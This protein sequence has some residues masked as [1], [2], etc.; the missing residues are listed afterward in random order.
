MMHSAS[1]TPL[2]C[3]LRQ[4]SPSFSFISTLSLISQFLALSYFFLFL[5]LFLFPPPMPISIFVPIAPIST[6]LGLADYT[7][8][9]THDHHFPFP[10]LFSI[11]LYISLHLCL[12]PIFAYP[13]NIHQ[14]WP[15]LLSKS[16]N[17]R[18]S[19]TEH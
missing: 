3:P 17:S 1:G 15:C 12:F 5:T 13:T 7:R 18:P 14:P 9:S 19:A 10:H 2:F 6:N 11:S 4:Y 16:F 8:V